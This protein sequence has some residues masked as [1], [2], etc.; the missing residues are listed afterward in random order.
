M[1]AAAAELIATLAALLA[2]ALVVVIR[3][4]QT[5]RQVRRQ[6][7][8][9]QARAARALDRS[10]RALARNERANDANGYRPVWTTGAPLEGGDE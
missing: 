5:L 3:Q 4:R 10:G 7:D 8:R 6:R 1:T 2:G 9:A